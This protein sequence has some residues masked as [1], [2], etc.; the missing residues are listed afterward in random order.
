MKLLIITQAVDSKNQVLGFFTQWLDEFAR[1]TE[2]V[3]VICLEKGEYSP[4]LNVQVY[5]LNKKPE[6]SKIKYA[7]R[8]LSLIH[9]H[10]DS[11]DAVFVHMNPIYVL[12]GA[13][14]WKINQKPITLWYTHKHISSTLR[15]AEKLVDQVF[16][17]SPESFLLKS[18]KLIVAGHG[19]DTNYFQPGERKPKERKEVLTIG[20]ISPIKSYEDMIEAI[21]LI[22]KSSRPILRIIGAP[23]NPEQETYYQN[24]LQLIKEKRVENDIIFQGPVKHDSIV[25]FLQQADILLN[26]SNTDSL[27]KAILEAMACQLRPITSN[28]AFVSILGQYGLI[29]PKNDPQTLAEKIQTE[30]SQKEENLISLRSI[31]IKNHSLKSLIPKLI[32]SIKK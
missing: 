2:K 17:A 26:L 24:L 20:R 29:V 16:T 18:K 31:I 1:Q 27:D 11:Y 28:K 13:I 22:P 8:F 15:I 7:L 12:L 5:S 9:K 32:S 30:L 23:I 21:S 25:S 10:K 14:I 3:T 6:T 4:P 19:I